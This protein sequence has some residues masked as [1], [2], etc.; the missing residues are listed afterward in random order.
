MLKGGPSPHMIWKAMPREWWNNS[1]DPASLDDCIKQNH[2]PPAITPLGQLCEWVIHFAHL[3][4][5]II[6]CLW[7][8]SRTLSCLGL[9]QR[10]A[11]YWLWAK[12]LGPQRARS[13]IFPERVQAQNTVYKRAIKM[14]IREPP[15]KRGGKSQGSHFSRAQEGWQQIWSGEPFQ[16]PASHQQNLTF[17]GRLWEEQDSH[18][19][20]Q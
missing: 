17:P 13:N 5:G 2:Q 20:V 16:Q 9:P 7:Y 11:I 15:Q 14:T 4:L 3:S 10:H 1:E 12:P 8:R 6:M 18:S 19:Q